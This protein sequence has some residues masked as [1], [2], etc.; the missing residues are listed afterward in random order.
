MNDR[1]PEIGER[2]FW[3]AHNQ[4]QKCSDKHSNN[5]LRSSRRSGGSLFGTV[6]IRRGKMKSYQ[7]VIGDTSVGIEKAELCNKSRKDSTL[8]P[9]VLKLWSQI[10]M[11]A[12][13]EFSGL[14]VR[15]VSEANSTKK[16]GKCTRKMHYSLDMNWIWIPC[17]EFYV[18]PCVMNFVLW[19]SESPWITIY[20]PQLWTIYGF[21]PLDCDPLRL[22]SEHNAATTATEIA[23]EGFQT[24][25]SF[26]QSKSNLHRVW[27]CYGTIFT[28]N[29][30][31][32][33]LEKKLECSLSSPRPIATIKLT[34]LI[35]I[36]PPIR[37]CWIE[38]FNAR[39]INEIN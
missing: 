19:I 18:L 10:W 35:Q 17:Y 15:T 7:A 14:T 16:N 12:L 32:K 31:W 23:V 39:R 21:N 34:E 22:A 37:A 25:E 4:N 2:V 3:E 30:T 11:K 20:G 26:Q 9:C 24:V 28:V 8:T 27:A 13:A 36:V 1:W 33:F 38:H 5:R 6:D 29:F